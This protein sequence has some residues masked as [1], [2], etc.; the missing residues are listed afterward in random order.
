MRIVLTLIF[1]SWCFLCLGQ[2]AELFMPR[3]FEVSYD[4]GFRNKNGAP[5]Q[6]YWQNG[7]D[8]RILV[9][10]NPKK[11][12]VDVHQEATYYNNSPDTLRL[13]RIKVQH[14]LYKKGGQRGEDVDPNDI[15]D[16]VKV[17]RLEING[18]IIPDE[19]QNRHDCYLDVRL[20]KPLAPKSS[21]KINTD[22]QFTMPKAEDATRE[23]VCTPGSFFIPYFYP[24]IAVYDDLH[25]WADAP[26]NGLQEFYHDFS[27]FD[28][29]IKVPKGFGVWAT[30]EWQNAQE[31]LEPAYFEKWKKAHTSK[32]VVSIYSEAEVTSGKVFKKA[33][34]HTFHFVASSVPDFTFAASNHYNWDATSVVVDDKTG[35]SSFISAVYDSKSNDFKKV[36]RIAADGVGLMSRYLPGY[37]F[38]YPC[39]TVF[40]GNDGME[41][42][43]MINDASVGEDGVMGLTIHES[44]HTYF[45]F[46]MGINEQYYA[47]MDEGWANFFEHYTSDSLSHTSSGIWGGALGADWDVPPMVPSKNLSGNTYWLESYTRPQ[48]A[49]TQLLDMLGY[50][51]F[52]RCMTTYMDRWKGKHP[53]PYEFFNTFND[54]SG[55]NLNWFWK[56]WFFEFGTADLAIQSVSAMDQTG[57]GQSQQVVFIE[58]KG[59]M[60]VPVHVVLEYVDKTRDIKHFGAD[61]WKNPQQKVIEIPGAPGK[62]LQKVKLGGK[63]IPDSKPKDN[64]WTK[65]NN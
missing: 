27:N 11:A 14:D 56:P 32:E 8:Y 62:I 26:Y 4:K 35:R 21:V 57:S 47:W 50:E 64:S 60:P 53:G 52:H 45:P 63:T 12:L 43:M 22:W 61:I 20:S 18:V 44:A 34:F 33:K 24:E 31:I 5:G 38:P 58:K 23:C 59:S 40:N 30:G 19:K 29:K 3:N 37:P 25:G 46:M 9:E 16:G 42:P 7:A 13:I 2:D 65:P 39:L 10:L 41:Y 54:V 1:S 15:T 6:N 28:V 36:A 49:Y 48:I 17:K 55:Q 51:T